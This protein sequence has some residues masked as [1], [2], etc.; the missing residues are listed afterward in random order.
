MV[1]KRPHSYLRHGCP[2]RWTRKS[3]FF[4]SSDT[5]FRGGGFKDFMECPMSDTTDRIDCLKRMVFVL[6][7]GL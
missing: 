7:S 3:F 1:D 2:Y 4:L 6:V 5:P